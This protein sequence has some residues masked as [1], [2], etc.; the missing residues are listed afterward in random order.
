MRITV[1]RNEDTFTPQLADR[2]NVKTTALYDALNTIETTPIY[3]KL[4]TDSFDINTVNIPI[5]SY[6]ENS[7][8]CVGGHLY[9]IN[10]KIVF[11]EEIETKHYVEIAR[12]TT[13]PNIDI[14]AQYNDG[15][16]LIKVEKGTQSVY[17]Y[18]KPGKEARLYFYYIV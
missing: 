1:N 5:V 16:Y 18:G 12:L 7:S 10:C 2:I 8:F 9:I 17:L 15:Q 11:T 6:T 3:P 4:S 14:F 13:P